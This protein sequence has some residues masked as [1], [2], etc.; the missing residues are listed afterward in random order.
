MI[1]AIVAKR[2]R[3]HLPAPPKKNNFKS[4]TILQNT[5]NMFLFSLDQIILEAILK[6]EAIFNNLL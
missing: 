2:L 4:H 1:V 5:P 6:L 3:F